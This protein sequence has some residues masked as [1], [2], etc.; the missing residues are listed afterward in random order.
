MTDQ[1]ET[2]LSE[3]PNAGLATPAMD[4]AA[5]VVVAIIAIWFGRF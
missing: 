5:A 4:L 2:V 1:E 3:D